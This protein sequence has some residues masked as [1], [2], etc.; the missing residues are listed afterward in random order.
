M[1]SFRKNITGVLVVSAMLGGSIGSAMGEG[2]VQT[3]LVSNNP[4]FHPQ[5]LDPL[6]I[7]A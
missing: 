7:N 2:Y 1:R 6:V 4:N 5:I 3:N